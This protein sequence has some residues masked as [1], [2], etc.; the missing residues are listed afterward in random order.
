MPSHGGCVRE[1][2]EDQVEGIAGCAAHRAE[3]TA[4][5]GR[6]RNERNIVL[7]APGGAQPPFLSSTPITV[8][9]TLPM[10]KASP[11]GARPSK[12]S[13]AMTEPIT[14]TLAPDAI[15]VPVKDLPTVICHSRATR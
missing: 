6:K 10:R 9:G 13:S 7:A 11:I 8:K 3:H 12:S 5:R 15:S 2:N 14:A 1:L 4:F